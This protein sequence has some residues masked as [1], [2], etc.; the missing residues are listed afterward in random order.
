MNNSVLS[1]RTDGGWTFM[2]TII[3]IAIILILSSSVGV[4]TIRYLDRARVAA[5]RSQIDSLSI[6]LESYYIDCG[7]YPSTEQ[8]LGALWEKPVIEPTS[9]S[10]NGPYI[11]KN[12]PDDPWGNRYDYISPGPNN[13]PYSIRSFGADGKEGGENNDAD[14]LSSQT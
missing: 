8:G 14:I 4:I 9:P 6:A 3:V 5:A 1:E 13:L 7:R 2:E 10:W 11:Y 12:I